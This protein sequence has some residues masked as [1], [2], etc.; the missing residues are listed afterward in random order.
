MYIPSSK[1][2]MSEEKFSSNV[3]KGNCIVYFEKEFLSQ[4][5]GRRVGVGLFCKTV[6]NKEVNKE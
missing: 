4:H 2:L 6:K 5:C 3:T 1:E